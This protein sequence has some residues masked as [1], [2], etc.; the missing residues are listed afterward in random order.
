MSEYVV[1]D[2]S[3]EAVADAIRTRGGTSAQL[4][5]PADFVLAIGNIPSGSLEWPFAV[6]SGSITPASDVQNLVITVDAT[7]WKCIIGSFGTTDYN[8]WP[9]REHT[10]EYEKVNANWFAQRFARFWPCSY[11]GGDICGFYLDSNANGHSWKSNTVQ[12]LSFT[13]IKVG[14]SGYKWKAGETVHWLLIG[15][16]T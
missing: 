14:Y 6:L 2:S 5:F 15:V 16:T 4:E 11:G 10:T 12:T 13:Q 3:L 9:D 1:S 7:S 8:G